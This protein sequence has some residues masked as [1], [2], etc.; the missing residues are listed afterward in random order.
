MRSISDKNIPKLPKL[1]S[2]QGRK[3]LHILSLVHMAAPGGFTKKSVDIEAL[4]AQAAAAE[5]EEKAAAAGKGKKKKEKVKKE[6]VK[7]D[8]KKIK[9]SKKGKEKPKK[10][11]EKKEKKS[12]TKKKSSKKSK[13]KK[14]GGDELEPR[15]VFGVNL[16]D[17]NIE[18]GEVPEV[19]GDLI[20]CLE[21]HGKQKIHLYI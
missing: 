4:M 15:E 18:E 13:K 21:G 11:K 1:Q 6:R 12:S 16:V 2:I 8:D 3:V 14:G 17:L 10:E 5:E 19:F 7:K 9:T 20:T